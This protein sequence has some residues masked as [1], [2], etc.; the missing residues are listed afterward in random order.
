MTSPDLDH[1]PQVIRSLDGTP[2]AVRHM[3][4][5]PG[6]PLLVAN[7]VGANLAPWRSVLRPLA[8]EGPI[9]TW[10]LRGTYGSGEPPNA[11]FGPGAHAE[12]AIAAM[13]HL[14]IERFVLTSWSSGGRIAL[15][16]AHRHP[17]RVAALALVSAGYGYPLTRLLRYV[18]L[19]SLLP[20]AA[21][22]A[23]LFAHPLQGVFRNLVARPELAGLV[24]QSGMIS[25][26][27]DIGALVELAQ[28]VASCDLRALLTSYEEVVGDPAPRLLRGIVSP[29]LLVVGDKDRFTPR[30]MIDEMLEELPDASLVTYPGATH[31]LPVEQPAS[32]ARDLSCFFS[33]AI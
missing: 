33:D 19:P 6:M 3:G 25:A 12:D 21:G 15:E 20:R 28:G 1:E 31:F 30:R 27:A 32:L 17:D 22:L 23:K 29:T 24:R 11:R 26:S 9:V 4:E 7:A 2:I 14:G 16:I 5:G 18:E 13:D 10:D 8:A